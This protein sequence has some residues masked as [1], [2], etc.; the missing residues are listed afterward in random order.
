MAHAREISQG[1]V[2][3]AQA[4]AAE[5]T[6]QA[7]A[8]G[9]ASAEQDTGR[10]WTAAH[11]RARAIRLAAGRSLY[12]DLRAAAVEAVQADRR[13]ADLLRHVADAARMRLGPGASVRADGFVV[14]ATRLNAH[15]RWTLQ[16]AVDESLTRLG[17][18]MEELWS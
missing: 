2:S 1:I 18:E 12:D 16:D 4:D 14:D 10:E 11:R 5:L 8:D 13:A 9:Q 6:R 7:E 17:A 3:K 15:V